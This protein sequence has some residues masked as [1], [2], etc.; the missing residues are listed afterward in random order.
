MILDCRETVKKQAVD[1]ICQ[2][3]TQMYSAITKAEND[4]QDQNSIVPRNPEQ[5]IRLLS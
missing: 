4:Y 3:Y 5:I 1:L 2:A